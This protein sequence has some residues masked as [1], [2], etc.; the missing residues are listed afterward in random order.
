[1]KL[2]IGA[3]MEADV[4][5]SFRQS[6]SRVEGNINRVIQQR[7]YDLPFSSW[8]CIAILRDDTHFEERT[9]YSPKRKDMDFRLRLD[10][11]AFK[12]GTPSQQ[13]A[14]IFDMLHRS[15]TLLAVKI[16]DCAGLQE[17]H[18]DLLT[19]RKST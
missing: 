10:Y 18:A 2:W 17:L 15:L 9:R 11:K 6:R 7:H 1:M 8:D 12:A 4:A 19:A 3:E 14:M 16:G 5:D 13:D